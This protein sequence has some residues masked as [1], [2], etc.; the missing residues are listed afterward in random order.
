MIRIN[1]IL[2]NNKIPCQL[3]ES[4]SYELKPSKK[5][6]D[7]KLDLPSLDRDA[8]VGSTQLQNFTLVY[9]D[10]ELLCMKKREKCTRCIVF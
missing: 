4:E 1:S 6:G 2:Y 5:N 3:R 8:S 7:A 9:R 10:S